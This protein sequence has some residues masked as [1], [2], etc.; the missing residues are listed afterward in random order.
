[1]RIGLG[2]DAHNLKRGRG[3]VL[4]GVTIPFSSGLAGHSDGDV[5]LH[6]VTDALLGAAALPD[7]GALFPDTDPAYKEADSAMLLEQVCLTVRKRGWRPAGLDCVVVCD[8]PA[9]APHAEAI[10][11]SIGR[12]LSLKPDLVGFKA[13]TTEGTNL[14][15]PGRSI[16]ALA[17]VLLR[18]V[19]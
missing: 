8:R 12:L 1:M 17:T 16:A 11:S 13:K 19:K 4:G 5:L 10:R 18:R 9:L 2:F 14:A 7:I 6:A 15:I 3:L